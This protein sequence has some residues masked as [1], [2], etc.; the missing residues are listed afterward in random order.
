MNERIL[1][2]LADIMFA[3]DEIRDM[4]AMEHGLPLFDGFDE[5]L[6]RIHLDARGIMGRLEGTAMSYPEERDPALGDILAETARRLAALRRIHGRERDDALVLVEAYVG[7]YVL[8]FFHEIERL[9]TLVSR[10][11]S[12]FAARRTGGN[13]SV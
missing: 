4:V 6:G 10:L 5:A 9:D 7:P 3:A 8:A 12:E 1:D 2:L 11:R 13:E